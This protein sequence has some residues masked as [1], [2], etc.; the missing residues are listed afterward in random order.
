MGIDWSNIPPG[1]VFLFISNVV[2][3]AVSIAGLYFGLKASIKQLSNDLKIASMEARTALDNRGVQIRTDMNQ[4]I[5]VLREKLISDVNRLDADVREAH[6]RLKA[7]ETG[8]DEWSRTLRARSH[9]LAN[10]VNKLKLKII[11]LVRDMEGQQDY[12]GADLD[13][14]D[15]GEHD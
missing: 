4:T 14:R 15:D 9:R 2:G 5:G 7:L 12:T 13:V 6:N 8:S 1:V 11:L 10:Q 3:S